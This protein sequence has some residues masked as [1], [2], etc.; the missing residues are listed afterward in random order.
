MNLTNISRSDEGVYGCETGEVGACLRVY[1]K[2]CPLSI[3]LP[4]LHSYFRSPYSPPH[5]PSPQPQDQYNHVTYLVVYF[6]Y[7]IFTVA[8]AEFASPEEVH[9]N[10][11][12]AEGASV[13]FDATVV[14][15]PSLPSGM[16]G[17]TQEVLFVLLDK[18]GGRWFVYSATRKEI[19]HNPKEL[20]FTNGSSE[21]GFVLTLPNISSVD[22]AGLYEVTVKLKDPYT[23][24]ESADPIKKRFRLD[25]NTNPDTT[26]TGINIFWCDGI[27]TCNTIPFILHS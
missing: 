18:D 13:S 7:Y 12:A 3:P 22:Q 5:S 20:D 8:R 14:H 17:H 6:V 9:L 1:G 24:E 27:W 10:V 2:Q 23:G 4:I 21:L 16:C 25:V 19:I 11:T 15:R 26:T